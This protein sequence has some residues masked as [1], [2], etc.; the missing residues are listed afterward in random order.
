MGHR[1]VVGFRGVVPACAAVLT[2]LMPLGSLEA[3]VLSPDAPPPGSPAWMEQG[4]SL[5]L[6]V[7]HGM[8]HLHAEGF[9]WRDCAARNVLLCKEDGDDHLLRAK[10]VDWQTPCARGR[11][12]QA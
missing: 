4:V 2:D 3:L 5:L 6:D 7:A 12:A 11:R 10:Y 9:V 1:R 8:S